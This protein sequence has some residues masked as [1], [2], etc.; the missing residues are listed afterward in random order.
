MSTPTN[1]EGFP[2]EVWLRILDYSTPSIHRTLY[3]LLSAFHQIT[4]KRLYHTL[5]FGNQVYLGYTKETAYDGTWCRDLELF[6][7]LHKN[8]NDWKPHV[9]R[10]YIQCCK[11][12]SVVPDQCA[13]RRRSLVR[14]AAIVRH[15]LLD[16]SWQ[17]NAQFLQN[18]GSIHFKEQ[19]RRLFMD[20]ATAETGL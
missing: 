7:K 6:Y 10:V 20:F 17:T 2:L 15:L 9:H 1:F 12:T 4:R 18:I 14:A 16:F 5:V 11:S 19:Y 13:L 3:R 8:R